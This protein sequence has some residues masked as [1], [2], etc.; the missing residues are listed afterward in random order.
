MIEPVVNTNIR[1]NLVVYTTNT[2]DF[3]GCKVYI[4]Q[5]I[6]CYIVYYSESTFRVKIHVRLMKNKTVQNPRKTCLV[7]FLKITFPYRLQ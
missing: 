5:Y 4:H 2:F 3:R 6:D 7:C 1:L